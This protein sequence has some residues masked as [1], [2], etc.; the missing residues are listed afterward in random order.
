[1]V[2]VLSRGLDDGIPPPQDTASGAREATLTMSLGPGPATY[3]SDA[4]AIEFELQAGSLDEEL[5]L[6]MTISQRLAFVDCRTEGLSRWDA[7]NA[8]TSLRLSGD[9]DVAC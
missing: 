1:M 3:V 5:P 9:G 2:A 8:K 4:H 7:W 6:Q